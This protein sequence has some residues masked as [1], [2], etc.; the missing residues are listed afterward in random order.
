MTQTLTLQ[1][2]E[3]IY[4]PLRAI[5]QRR[6]Q[7]AEEF[8]LEWL[9]TSI[10]HFT[11]DPLEPLLGSVQSNI[12]DWTEKADDYLGKNLLNSEGSD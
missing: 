7:S 11:D 4:Q 2:P 5:A 12:A 3:E 8:T 1:I 10:Q 6:G 9:A